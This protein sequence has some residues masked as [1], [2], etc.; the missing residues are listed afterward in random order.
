MR[1]V[2]SYLNS[3]KIAFDKIYKKANKMSATTSPNQQHRSSSKEREELIQLMKERL[4]CGDSRTA[5]FW[6]EKLLAFGTNRPRSERL[7]DF[8]RYLEVCVLFWKE[9][10]NNHNPSHIQALN[11]DQNWR[12]IVTFIAK[13]DLLLSHL[14]FAYYYVNALYHRQLYS[15]IIQLP[16]GYLVSSFLC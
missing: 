10:T 5:T 6:A 12:T 8:A 3:I 16:L 4:R 2:F 14:A 11:S 9:L 13:N 7:P 1:F 15:E